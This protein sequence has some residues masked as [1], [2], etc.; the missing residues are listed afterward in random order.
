M[1]D[2]TQ[3]DLSEL[4]GAVVTQ[5]RRVAEGAA[6]VGDWSAPTRVGDWDARTLLGHLVVVAEAIP[7]TLRL[8]ST[9]DPPV[10]VYTVF[11]GARDRAGG[12]DAKARDVAQSDDPAALVDRLGRAVDEAEG[13][14]G[15]LDLLAV[16][17]TRFGPVPVAD[18]LV[19]RC[20]EGVVHGLD[21]P[22]PV[23]P[24]GVALAVAAAA[25][26]WLLHLEHPG[27]E[28]RVPGDHRLWVE[29]ATGR[30]PAPAGLEQ[31]LPV[32]S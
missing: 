32:L 26:A 25:L 4:H 18:F 11:A 2:P 5:W 6:R 21:L 19:H 3:R 10:T 1:E 17:P 22:E 16:L 28:A 30:L 7:A 12:N 24:D 14:E 13:V 29:A 8:A 9:D 20:V 15:Q 27:A 31:A 23:D